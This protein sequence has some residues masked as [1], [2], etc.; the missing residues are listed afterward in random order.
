MTPRASVAHYDLV[1][2]RLRFGQLRPPCRSWT[3]WRVAIVE[4]GTFGGT[5]L[6][7]GCI[8]RRCTSTPPTSPPT[9]ASAGRLGVV[10]ARRRGGVEGDIRDRIFGRIDAISAMRPAVPRDGTPNVT[11]YEAHAEF[12]APRTL[13]LVAPA[14]R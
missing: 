11:L 8:R 7:V 2:H 9:P 3:G 6:N 13:Q 4:H 5:C 1:D 10:T 12:T 14:R